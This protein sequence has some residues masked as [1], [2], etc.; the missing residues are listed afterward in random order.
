M[1]TFFKCADC[2]RIKQAE[3]D[4][5]LC[6]PCQRFRELIEDRIIELFSTSQTVTGQ[7][8]I[9]DLASFG[10]DEDAAS[11]AWLR[12][13]RS[14]RIAF[15]APIE[16]IDEVTPPGVDHIFDIHRCIHE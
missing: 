9:D 3:E 2:G 6:E 5:V 1:T 12:L 13:L 7:Q 16:L 8:M 10:V 15:E 14:H 4:A 11:E